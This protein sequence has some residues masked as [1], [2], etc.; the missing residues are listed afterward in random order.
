MKEHLFDFGNSLWR[1][2]NSNVGSVLVGAT[3]SYILTKGS[4]E[5]ELADVKFKLDKSEEKISILQHRLYE[6]Q[7]N[8]SHLMQASI[9][10]RFQLQDCLRGQDNLKRIYYDSY[11]LFRHP[12][13]NKSIMNLDSNEKPNVPA[14]GK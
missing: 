5:E 14:R 2:A 13:S 10:A 9:D 12:V 3:V 8:S 6:C 4:R 11:C 1:Y 7:S